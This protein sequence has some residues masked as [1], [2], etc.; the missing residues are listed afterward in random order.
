MTEEQLLRLVGGL[1]ARHLRAWCVE[2][3]VRPRPTA[4]GLDY[5]EID[6]ARAR[7]IHEM[8]QELALDAE[9]VPIVLSLIDQI[10]GLRQS[11]MRLARAIEAEPPEVRRRI[12]GG[13]GEE[14]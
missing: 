6:A 14:G 11:L 10:H 1:D 9:A 12:V 5:T 8:R 4:T 7:L 3:W 13:L 2:G